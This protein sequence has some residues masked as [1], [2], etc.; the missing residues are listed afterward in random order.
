[1][2]LHA[3]LARSNN[4]SALSDCCPALALSCIF[5][6]R[7]DCATPTALVA[8]CSRASAA[9]MSG[10]R[11]A[12]SEGKLTG[13]SSGSVICAKSI[14][15]GSSLAG[16]RPSTTDSAWR[17]FA[18]SWRND[19][20]KVMSLAIWLCALTISSRATDPLSNAV[21]TSR[22][23]SRSCM[24]IVSTVAI[25]ARADAIASVCMTAWPV[26]VRYAASS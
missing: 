8:A 4:W 11:W 1:M 13:K 18:R 21:C 26:T 19:G 17:A 25:C 16:T 24:R 12:S 5:G 9:K 22:R 23:L 6:Y 14:S 20:S 3:L 7:L 15:G 2:M 10:R